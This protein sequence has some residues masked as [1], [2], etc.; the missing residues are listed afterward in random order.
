MKAVYLTGLM[1][2]VPFWASAQVLE[3][4]QAPQAQAWPEHVE[5]R[6][7]VTFNPTVLREQQVM[8]A[9]GGTGHDLTFLTGET[10][11]RSDDG[12]TWRGRVRDGSGRDGTATITV[13]GER[14]RGSLE[15]DGHPYQLSTDSGGQTWFDRLDLSQQPP[16]HPPGGPV[17][18]E[19]PASADK[20]IMA[21]QQTLTAAD[22]DTDGEPRVDVLVFY[23]PASI[24]R[25]ND[26]PDLR[27]AIHNAVDAANTGLMNSDVGGRFRLVGVLPYDY[28]ENDDMGDGLSDIR[29][30]A[31][32]EAISDR[33]SADLVAMIGEY[34]DGCGRGYLL[35]HYTDSWSFHYS[36]TAANPSCL[37]GQTFAHELGHNL[38]LHHD[39]ANAGDPE[40]LI[41]EFAYGHFVDGQFRTIMS[42]WTECTS[43]SSCPQI[44]HFSDPDVKDPESGLPTGQAD[45]N[46]AEVLRRTMAHA[47]QWREQPA[48]LGQALGGGLG[49]YETQGDGVW[50]VQDEV[51]FNDQPTALSGPV[52]D[53]ETSIL[54]LTHERD[55]AFLIAFETRSLNP[56]PGGILELRSE[57]ELLKSVEPSEPEWQSVSV[58][59]P[60]DAE[61]LRWVWRA[62]ADARAS[63]VGQVLVADVRELASVSLNGQVVNSHNEGVSAVTVEALDAEGETVFNSTGTNDEGHFSLAFTQEQDESANHL[64]LSGTGVKENTI[65]LDDTDCESGCTLA[66]EGEARTIA[67]IVDGAEEGDTITVALA[68]GGSSEQLSDSVAADASGAIEF[69]FEGDAL[70]DWGP[71][72]AEAEGYETDGVA[73]SALDVR[74]GDEK[75]LALSLEAPDTS[76]PGSGGSTDEDEDT[77]DSSGSGGSDDED[78]DAGDSDSFGCT[79]GGPGTGFD[80]VLPLLL[81][82]AFLGLR[83]R[84]AGSRI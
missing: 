44:D 43:F 19:S 64:L 14:V 82:G 74:A 80:P 60:L 24:S 48:T 13:Q 18:P 31:D 78:G 21:A 66:V 8:A 1:A 55:E 39:P 3:P 40:S 28:T 54:S 29:S 15:I 73:R 59:V 36:V 77:G 72:E 61:E 65:M 16:A 52:F 68:R 47:E 50:V 26:E 42:Y 4:A 22:H 6:R 23:T 30:D 58:E 70:V 62:Q 46:N 83:R 32:V 67:G 53:D 45:R 76:E 41:E 9:D 5:D 27:L 56:E 11:V 84:R 79:I 71:L 35:T 69:S 63:E 81:A 49:E 75:S 51:E 10:E 33:H 25:Y 20:P 17:I 34:S 2:L 57:T 38:G 7:A 37:G 12:F